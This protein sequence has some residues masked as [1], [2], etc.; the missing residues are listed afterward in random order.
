MKATGA[1]L[2]LIPLLLVGCASVTV[3]RGMV[4]PVPAQCELTDQDAYVYS[5][6]R[7]E[8]LSP[9]IH[10]TGTVANIINNPFDGDATM[11]LEVDPPFAQ[12]L[13]ATNIAALN[14][15]LHIEVICFLGPIVNPNARAACAANPDPL[16]FGI[17]H[18]GQHVWM[19]G[20]WV[21]DHSHGG[22]AELHPLYR[23]GPAE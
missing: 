8:A 1:A 10:V 13:T 4:T 20:R 15:T 12:Y 6:D 23:W 18:V 16:R 19:E 22:W 21:L 9:C 14:G 2:A 5:E 11:G 3:P 17:P 7:L